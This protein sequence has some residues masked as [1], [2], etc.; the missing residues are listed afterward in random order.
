MWEGETIAQ[1]GFDAPPIIPNVGDRLYWEVK[2]STEEPWKSCKGRFNV[3]DKYLMYLEESGR[4]QI[5]ILTVEP[6]LSYDP[7]LLISDLRITFP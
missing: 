1:Q 6:M 5:L 3:K 2:D 7:D 4:G